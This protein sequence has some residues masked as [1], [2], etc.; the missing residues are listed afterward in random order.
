MHHITGRQWTVEQGLQEQGPSSQPGWQVLGEP[1]E[2]ALGGWGNG[3]KS[4]SSHDY[5]PQE[6][7]VGG[8]SASVHFLLCVL[9]VI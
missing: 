2:G 7:R 8:G 9:L 5:A 4:H 1:L 3:E 6:N